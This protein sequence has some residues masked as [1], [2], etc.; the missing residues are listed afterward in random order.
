MARLR[1]MAVSQVSGW[2]R[3]ASKLAAAFHTP[4]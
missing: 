1:A 2:V 3:A 4:T